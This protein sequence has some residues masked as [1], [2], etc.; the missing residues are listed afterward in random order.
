M[1]LYNI[2]VANVLKNLRKLTYTKTFKQERPRITLQ[3]TKLQVKY[4]SNYR[5][6]EK[7][8]DDAINTNCYNSLEEIQFI[9]AER[10]T[11]IDVAKPFKNVAKV[12]FTDG[13][14]C[15]L[16]QNFGE[17]FPNANTLEFVGVK[18]GDYYDEI[19]LKNWPKLKNLE[20]QPPKG[21][22]R[23]TSTFFQKLIAMNMQLESISLD[24]RGSDDNAY[25]LDDIP[26]TSDLPNLKTLELIFEMV[27]EIRNTNQQML[28]FKSL[29]RLR[30]E[31]WGEIDIHGLSISVDNLHSLGLHT[32]FNIE[33]VMKFMT[34]NKSVE[35]LEC[36]G[37][38]DGNEL[39]IV[40]AFAS[41]PK[42]QELEII[43]TYGNP[44]DVIIELLKSCKSLQKL[45]IQSEQYGYEDIVQQ[46][47][48]DINKDA[49]VKHQWKV[50][51]EENLCILRKV[52][53]NA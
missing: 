44:N 48:C 36:E 7:T 47:K 5:R 33:S 15:E 35:L 10:F 51:P 16:I 37:I 20:I 38:F 45:T 25:E 17:V 19:E 28:H 3:I 8:M 1:T 34:R 40:E 9:N 4:D 24:L 14:V 32:S 53:L 30:I 21:Q 11:M 6:C 39:K 52:I 2:R 46:A 26:I 41:L 13:S 50:T 22:I 43:F 31:S 27:T 12:T 29:N 42:L 23:S 18:V 49:S